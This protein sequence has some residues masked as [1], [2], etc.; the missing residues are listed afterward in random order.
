MTQT[1]WFE[2]VLVAVDGSRNSFEA[3]KVAGYLMEKLE[4]ASATVIL[5]APALDIYSAPLAE[6][7]YTRVDRDAQ[8]QLD[9][10]AL[11]IEGKSVKIE[12]EV[13]HSGG[14]TV[15]AIIEFASENKSDLVVL[16]TRGYGGIRKMLLGS[17]SSGVA[18]HAQCPVLVVRSRGQENKTKMIRRIL[19]AVDGSKAA[20][21]A[22]QIA[23]FLTR[24]LGG[25][26]IA[27]YVVS[28]PLSGFY[29]GSASAIEEMERAG[30]QAGEQATSSAASI[31]ADE[32]V[33]CTREVLDNSLSAA[34]G[35]CEYARQADA[36]LIVVGTRGLGGFRKLLLGS[37]A[38]AVLNYAPCSV[39]VVR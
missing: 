22:A 28:L 12:Q 8:K 3:C 21:K 14:S 10:G 15:N 1:T 11:L 23:A 16:G 38:T 36:D 5:V 17:V 2:K 24:V 35:I 33:R 19:V 4:N 27:V 6:E 18:A 26:L 37:V 39:L 29:S 32:G 34:S 25:E 31:A 20:T 30:L 9:A 7:V 13:V